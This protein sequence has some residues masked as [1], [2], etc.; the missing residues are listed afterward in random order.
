LA[1]DSHNYH[2]SRAINK[3]LS[4]YVISANMQQGFDVKFKYTQPNNEVVVKRRFAKDDSE[5]EKLCVDCFPAIGAFHLERVQSG[6]VATFVVIEG[7]KT[8]SVEENS[9]K[10]E[11][12]VQGN[13]LVDQD[14]RVPN[15]SVHPGWCFGLQYDVDFVFFLFVLFCSWLFRTFL[16]IKK[17]L[18]CCAQSVQHYIQLQQVLHYSV[19]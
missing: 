14:V 5:L 6:G 12:V 3:L 9:A 17:R 18:R 13:V 7:K 10:K 2:R 1:S 8:E 4:Y 16:I 19:T 15:L 11:K